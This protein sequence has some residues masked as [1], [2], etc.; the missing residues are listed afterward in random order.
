MKEDTKDPR[1]QRLRLL[2]MDR[3]EWACV[4]CGA[5][6]RTLHVHHIKY[7]GRLW[8]APPEDLQTLCE[9]CHSDLGHHPKGGVKYYIHYDEQE[10]WQTVRA[11]YMHCP[12]CGCA[13][14]ASHS[15][16]IIFAC[17]HCVDIP[18][19]MKMRFQGQW[20]TEHGEEYVYSMKERRVSGRE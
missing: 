14:S 13:E 11:C 12:E 6:D 9:Q 2:I 19:R 17:G 16:V 8:D 5:K 20:R 1:W 10:E 18:E 3:D 7:T 4:A 15:G